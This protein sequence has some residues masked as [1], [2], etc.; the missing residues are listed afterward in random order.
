MLERY[1][2]RPQPGQA[3]LVS[4]YDYVASCFVVSDATDAAKWTALRRTVADILDGWPGDVLGGV[5]EP[6][7]SGLAVKLAARSAQ[8]LA[9]AQ[10]AL[11]H[12]IRS[13]YSVYR[14]LTCVAIKIELGL[15]LRFSW[16]RFWPGFGY[17]GFFFGQLAPRRFQL[18]FDSLE[19]FG[20]FD[21]QI[22]R[23]L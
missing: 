11:W 3:S 22:F 18:L 19:F 20:L 1:E 8:G 7:V 21:D 16:I 23:G 6:S 14:G 13:G 9:A 4:A 2:V 10:E 5:T 15:E 12:A 17:G